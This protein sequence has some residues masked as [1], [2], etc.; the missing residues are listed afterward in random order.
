MEPI[1]I[2]PEGLVRLP[3]SASPIIHQAGVSAHGRKRE[4]RLFRPKLWAV[5]LYFWQ[6]SVSFAGQS[7]AIQP[8]RLGLTPPD[9]EL[10]WRFP[11]KTCPHYFI[12]FELPGGEEYAL[13]PAMQTLRTRF[14]RVD[15]R[16]KGIV[17]AWQT[18]RTRA[19]ASLWDMLWELAEH[20]ATPVKQP[21]PPL[22]GPVGS[23]IV[24]GTFSYTATA[25]DDGDV[26][27]LVARGRGNPDTT[28]R[29]ALDNVS[30]TA[31]AIPEPAT[32]VLLLMGGLGLAAYGWRR[33]R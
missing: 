23:E 18:Q 29:A 20:W 33:R 28:L 25:E 12:H 17:E 9:T 32:L 4:E 3:L 7:F 14:A 6:G 31:T 19:Q 22:P 2:T 26:L 15:A 24:V 10:I 1:T 16:I 21:N 8:H 11:E 27:R 30:V 5:H 13:V